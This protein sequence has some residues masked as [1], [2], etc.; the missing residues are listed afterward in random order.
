MVAWETLGL[1]LLGVLYRGILSGGVALALALTLNDYDIK[2]HWRGFLLI[3][4][5]MGSAE[6]VVCFYFP[7]EIRFVLSAIIYFIGFKLF[8]RFHTR[9]AFLLLLITSFILHV[10]Y[11]AAS[12]LEIF[13]LGFSMPENSISPLILLFLLPYNICLATVTYIGYQKHWR[14]FSDRTETKIPYMSILPLFVQ[15]FFSLTVLCELLQFGLTNQTEGEIIALALVATMFLSFFFI[16]Q[17]LH[18]AEREAMTAAQEKLAAEMIGQA[19][20]TRSQRHDFINH[21]QVMIA[22]LQNGQQDELAQY[23]KAIE[24]NA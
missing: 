8:F 21:V 19:D 10:G 5:L 11:L 15:V 23:V 9:K 12:F 14:L 1:T 13:A 20:E 7:E 24:Q 18:V 22:F 16:W 17:I 2:K 6:G 4:L 3:S